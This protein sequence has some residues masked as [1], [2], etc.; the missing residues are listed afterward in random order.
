M[1][2]QPFILYDPEE[3]IEIVFEEVM[4]GMEKSFANEVTNFRR[5]SD[6]QY[7]TFT[8]VQG[9]R[10]ITITV[11]TTDP[12]GIR[13]TLD[14]LRRDKGAKGL[15]KHLFLFLSTFDFVSEVVIKNV[16][17]INSTGPKYPIEITFTCFGFLGQMRTAKDSRCSGIS[18]APDSYAVDGYA[19]VLDAQN[20]YV[21]FETVAGNVFMDAG[22]YAILAR[23]KSTAGTANDLTV[24]AYDATA[25]SAIITDVHSVT[26]GEYLYYIS[27]GSIAAAQFGH[28]M[29][30][31]ARKATTGT[32]AISVDL[33][34][35]IPSSQNFVITAPSGST[36]IE[37]NPT[38]DNRMRSAAATT[39]DG[40]SVYNDIGGSGANP[41]R[42]ILIFD[43]SSIPSGATITS[44]V[45]SLYWYYPAGATRTNSTVVQVYRPRYSWNPSYVCWANRASGTAWTNAG[46]DW[47]DSTG[48]A[49]GSSPFASV[50]FAAATVPDN[51]F[52]DFDVTDLVQAYVS[53]TYSNYGFLLKASTENSNYI[54]FYSKEYSNASMRPKL[55]ITYEV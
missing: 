21:R 54:A 51:M 23:A 22:D 10:E 26:I 4:E 24:R 29:Q 12:S 30:I 42:P 43:L 53:G 3:R 27:E 19:S 20:E 34:A 55:T 28:T 5:Y 38:Y 8:S 40:A 49:Q 45:L 14:Y 7:E 37:L 36:T 15:G 6:G 1:T 2:V 31:E 44:A 13:R 17:F 52:H 9:S 41:V 39:V 35:Y 25:S 11:T 16:R 48:T 18:E 32:N 46:G 50:T 47:Y 33:L